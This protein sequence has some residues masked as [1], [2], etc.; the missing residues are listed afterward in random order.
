MEESGPVEG[1]GLRAGS[2]GEWGARASA[3][4]TEDIQEGGG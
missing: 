2:G 4:G 1:E 3:R